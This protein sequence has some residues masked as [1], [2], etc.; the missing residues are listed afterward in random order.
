MKLGQKVRGVR[1]TVEASGRE[2]M[3]RTAKILKAFTANDLAIAASLPDAPVKLGEAVHYVNW[4]AR[5]G[6]LAVLAP[7]HKGGKGR[8][9]TYR[10]VRNTGPKPPM[11]LRTKALWDPN[12][13]QATYVPAPKAA[14]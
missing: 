1:K 13:H 14:A 9:T 11:I 6:Y 8:R 4:L 12:L 3:W 5:G 2:R 10:L 7:P